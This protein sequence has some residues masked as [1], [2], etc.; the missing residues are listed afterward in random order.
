M[1][2]RS[3]R[4]SEQDVRRVTKRAMDLCRTTEAAKN[5]I[6]GIC[7]DPYRDIVVEILHENARKI[8]TRV[9]F[10]SFGLGGFFF[11]LMDLDIL[12]NRTMTIKA[13]KGGWGKGLSNGTCV[14]RLGV[15]GRGNVPSYVTHYAL[16]TLCRCVR[17]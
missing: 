10:V 5:S 9:R 11:T 3:S 6:C 16:E 14:R 4:E 1:K 2:R 12:I 15:D 17:I 7:R 8:R 13:R